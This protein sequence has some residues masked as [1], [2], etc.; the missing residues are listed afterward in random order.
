MT[1]DDYHFPDAPRINGELPGDKS[2]F[3]LGEQERLEGNARSYP[4]GIPVA[5]DEGRGAT[6]K[7]V[8]GNVFIDFFGGAGTL[9]V[10]HSH[11]SVL[12]AAIAQQKKLIHTLDFPTERRNR[13]LHILKSVIPAGLRERVKF[14]FGG[15][16]GSD[17]VESALKLARY[18]TKRS[19]IV[20]FQ[21]SYHGMTAGAL[22][23][24]SNTSLKKHQ[25]SADVQFMP[26]PYCYRCPLGLER[27]SC[28]LACAKYVDNALSNSH[29]GV[30]PPAAILIE[31][32][33]GEGGTIIPP[34]GYLDE[35]RAI[36]DKHE[37]VLI[38]DEIQ[39]GFCRTGEMFASEHFGVTPDIM[40][41]SK[42][43]GG[44]GYPLSCIAYDSKLD[45]WGPGSHIGTF[46]GHQVAMAA[47]AEAISFMKDVSLHRYAAELGEYMLGALREFAR[48]SEVIGDVRGKGLMLGVEIVK[49]KQTKE[50]WPELVRHIRRQCY[51]KGLLVEVGGHYSNVVRFLPPLVLTR[52]LADKGLDI[53]IKAVES[54]E[55]GHLGGLAAGL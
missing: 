40:T 17:A 5:F 44:I 13:L 26:Y 19:T 38:F 12:D 45:T 2:K 39:S 49:D 47:G 43:L 22:G 51:R 46:R 14:Q 6:I 1:F 4:R 53:F 41:M 21:G 36:A 10:G 7:D 27:D 16:T 8:D 25:P 33:Q 24:T 35:V 31:P 50:P 3:L 54:R 48:S 9:N 34:D 18:N 42:A 23:V 15:P 28:G 29:S 55:S 30:N 37:T 32:I 20:A 11:P 52:E